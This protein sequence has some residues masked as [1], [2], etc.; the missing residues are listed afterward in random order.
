MRSGILVIASEPARPALPLAERAARLFGASREPLAVFS[1]DG[2][3]LYATGDLEPGT[4]LATLGGDALNAA[5][6][7]GS[8]GNSALG[9]SRRL[10]R[11]TAAA[12]Q[13]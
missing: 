2:A 9:C 6:A 11:M 12:A 1:A 13:P 7:V 4:T 10:E 8:G 5:I 3:L